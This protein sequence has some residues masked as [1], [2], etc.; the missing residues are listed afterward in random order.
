MN[1]FQDNFYTKSFWKL[2]CRLMYMPMPIP[3]IFVIVHCN[4]YWDH[5]ESI[6]LLYFI[7]S[8]HF[9]FLVCLL[10]NWTFCHTL[11]DLAYLQMFCNI[12]ICKILAIIVSHLD[13]YSFMLFID[14][15]LHFPAKGAYRKHSIS[16]VSWF[17]LRFSMR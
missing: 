7:Y 14:I 16:L 13:L 11:G 10:Q 5:L 4:C 15:H 2:L 6:S 17:H 1:I 8:W 12:Y 3:W 9:N